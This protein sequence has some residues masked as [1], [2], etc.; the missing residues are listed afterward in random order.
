MGHWTRSGWATGWIVAFVSMG[1]AG[2]CGEAPDESSFVPL[3]DGK[4][5]DGWALYGSGESPQGWVVDD[6]ALHRAEGGGDIR[7]A[8]P[9]DHFELKLDWKVGPGGN[10]GIMYRVREGDPAS[11]FSGPEYQI[12]DDDPHGLDDSSMT[13]AASLYDLVAAKGKELRPVGEYNHTRILVQG[14]HVEHWL[15]GK[16]VVDIDM[17]SDDWNQRVNASKFKEWEQFGKSSVGYLVLQDHGDP[18]WFK[19]IALRPLPPP[20]PADATCADVTTG[21]AHA[22]LAD[23]GEDVVVLDVRT[24]PEFAAGHLADAIM[25]DFRAPDFEAK[26]EEMDRDATYLVY[27]RSGRR[28]AGALSV[29]ESMGFQEAYNMLGGF[30]QWGAEKRAFVSSQPGE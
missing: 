2:K 9:Y 12:L 21:S 6:G 14:N 1:S 30:L 8:L 26:L 28:S 16:K 19:N 13:A 3:F 4:S 15:N 24:P 11:Y 25:V 22:L 27:C 7:T 18:V 5:T 29:M 17:H 20:D 23:R 10:S